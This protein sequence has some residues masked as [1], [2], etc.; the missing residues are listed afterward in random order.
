MTDVFTREK[1]SAIM[2][3]IR[4]KHTKPEI[5]VR[6]VLSG[7]GIRYRLHVAALPGAPDIVIH[8]LHTIIQVKGCFWHGHYCLRGRVPGSNRAYWVAKISS[9]IARDHRN[10]RKLR[11]MG[12]SVITLWECK[13]RRLNAEQLAA[14]LSRHLS[15][16]S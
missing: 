9:N 16:T 2:A 1:R 4:G 8:K 15:C 13:I 10:E 12:W 5:F 6:R 11:A 7:L 14:T 3:A